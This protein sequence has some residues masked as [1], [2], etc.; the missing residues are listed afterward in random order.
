MM[1]GGKK[2][3]LP[4]VISLVTTLILILFSVAPFILDLEKMSMSP[5]IFLAALFLGF[6][7]LVY[8]IQLLL[9]QNDNS[10][11]QLMFASFIYLPSL[12]TLFLIDKYFML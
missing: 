5:H 6:T 9:K 7:F 11:K 2:G 10:A 3:S 4:I 1:I 12:Q 8:S